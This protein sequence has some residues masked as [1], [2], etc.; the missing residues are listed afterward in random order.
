MNSFVNTFDETVVKDRFMTVPHSVRNSFT[1][2]CEPEV[3]YTPVFGE[4]ALMLVSS[5]VFTMYLCTCELC[6]LHGNG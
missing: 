4:E 2:C 1:D 6:F 3:M 5:P